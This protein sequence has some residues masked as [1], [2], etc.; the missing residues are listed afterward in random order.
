MDEDLRALE[1]AALT[2]GAA[3]RDRYARAL[4]RSGNDLGAVNLQIAHE[5]DQV[6]LDPRTGARL[7]IRGS[8]IYEIAQ[9]VLSHTIVEDIKVDEVFGQDPRSSH[10]RES[11]HQ[12][13]AA[14]ISDR[15]ADGSTCIGIK[16]ASYYRPRDPSDFFPSLSPWTSS[17]KGKKALDGRLRAF[18]KNPPKGVLKF[19]RQMVLAWAQ[20]KLATREWLVTNR[21]ESLLEARE[22]YYEAVARL[23]P[24]NFIRD[25]SIE[26]WAVRALDVF[27][28]REVNGCLSGV[29]NLA[30]LVELLGLRW[31]PWAALPASLPAPPSP[32]A[33]LPRL[34]DPAGTMAAIRAKLGVSV[35]DLPDWEPPE[36]EVPYRP[37]LYPGRPLDPKPQMT[38]KYRTRVARAEER[39]QRMARFRNQ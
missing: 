12:P 2:G 26:G 10:S 9:A 8:S 24:K 27:V 22:L 3:E 30:P 14:V 7:H 34:D 4:L 11:S 15:G 18:V 38:T 6:H 25:G 20:A 29:P 32:L 21:I 33:L 5:L 16:Q 39:R 36:R 31:Q 13:Y 17:D 35:T 19:P 23:T 37:S 28:D 1:R